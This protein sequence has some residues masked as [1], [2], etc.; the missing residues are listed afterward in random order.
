[1]KFETVVKRG[2]AI[3]VV[4][5][6]VPEPLAV[7]EIIDNQLFWVVTNPIS[8]QSAHAAVFSKVVQKGNGFSFYQ[9][10]ELFAY[11]GPFRE[12]V[13]TEELELEWAEW[14]S[15]LPNEMDWFPEFVK[16]VKEDL[17]G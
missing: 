11:V 1:M 3:E 2:A 6:G 14:T 4:S 13:G 12:F 17:L 7:A 16:G 10:E 15:N 9:G 5:V 8:Q